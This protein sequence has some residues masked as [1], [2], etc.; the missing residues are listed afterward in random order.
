MD[1][2]SRMALRLSD[3]LFLINDNDSYK[4]LIVPWLLLAQAF[5]AAA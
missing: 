4:V 5:G 2:S 1:G 3:L